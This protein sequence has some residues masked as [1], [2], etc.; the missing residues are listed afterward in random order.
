MSVNRPVT[1]LPLPPSDAA[2]IIEIFRGNYA[3]ELLTAAVA[4]FNVFG[5]LKEQPLS[6]DALRGQLKLERRPANVLITAL[7][8]MG[9]LCAEA[10]GRLT[11]MEHVAFLQKPFENQELLRVVR[12]LLDSI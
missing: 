11:E 3:T 12:Q 7:R 8:A 10:D 4:H 1:P 6:F 2:P 9:L 5:V